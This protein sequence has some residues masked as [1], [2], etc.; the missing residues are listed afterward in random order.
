MTEAMLPPDAAD[1]KPEESLFARRLAQT[2]FTVAMVACF[3]L[4]WW[5]GTLFRIPYHYR[6]EDSLLQ[7]PMWV[8][9]FLVIV[10]VYVVATA[11]AMLI[12]GSM[13]FIAG[14]LAATL[15]MTAL[16][17]RGG[18]M[19]CILFYTQASGG[20][21]SIFLNLAFELILLAAPVVAVWLYTFSLRHR[22]QAALEIDEPP[23]EPLIHDQAAQQALALLVQVVIMAIALMLLCATDAKKQAVISVGVAAFAGTSIAEYMFPAARMGKWYWLGPIAVGVVGYLSA[24]FN[25]DGWQI[26]RL[27]NL[28]A[29]LARPIPMD[30]ASAGLAGALA[31][32]WSGDRGA[33]LVG[34]IVLR[35]GRF[36]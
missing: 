23:K 11:L 12:T 31:G 7:Q 9:S 30:Y 22:T 1:P 36:M 19:R 29:P 34:L 8:V 17:M 4:F 13:H 32:L 33:K 27:H 16:T 35:S 26:A 6:F 5:A 21:V 2:L 14:L 24:Y 15:G 28:L 25:A 18:A 10:V 20:S 3:A